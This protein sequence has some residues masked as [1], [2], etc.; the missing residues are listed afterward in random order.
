MNIKEKILIVAAREFASKG[1]NKTTIRGI[2]K[3]AKVNVASINYYFRNKESLYK[4]M[5][6]FLFYETR[7]TNIFEGKLNGSFS[8]WKSIVREWVREIIL[9]IIQGNPLNQCKWKILEREMQ[10]PSEIFP[11]IYETFVKPRLGILASHFKRA[12]P[13]KTSNDDIYI[14]VFSVISNCIFYTH[15]RVLINMVFPDGKFI[16]NN[17][18]KIIN[19]IIDIACIGINNETRITHNGTI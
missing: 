13:A 8:E 7:G 15:D 10:D 3:R 11:N 18:E 9:D 2:C 14:R 6:E 16:T 5:F 17:M 12:L 1:Y 19:N 4:K